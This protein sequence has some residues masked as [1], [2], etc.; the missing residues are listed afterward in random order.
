MDRELFKQKVDRVFVPGNRATVFLG[1]CRDLLRVMPDQ[2][3]QLVVTSPPYNI[4]KVY[5]DKLDLHEY[6]RQQK[7]VIDECARVLQQTG[8]M[9]WEVG[10]WVKNGQIVPLDILLYD[11]FRLNGMKLRNRIVWHYRHGLHCKKR[12]SGRYETIAS[13]T[14]YDDY[15]FNLA[16]VGAP[17]QYPGKHHFKGAKT[18]RY[19]CSPLG[20]SPGD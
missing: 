12:F 1:D 16:P 6:V 7:Q 3:V 4:G 5:E 13:S 8:S 15:Y 17:Q 11:C 19:S 20:K 2:C 10:N 9:C 18:G 14:K